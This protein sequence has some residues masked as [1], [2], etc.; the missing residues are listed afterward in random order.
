MKKSLIGLKL[1]NKFYANKM[2]HIEKRIKRNIL[3][4]LYI[5]TSSIIPLISGNNEYYLLLYISEECSL[6]RRV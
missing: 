1:L 3:L 5:I 4:L 6:K 2:Q